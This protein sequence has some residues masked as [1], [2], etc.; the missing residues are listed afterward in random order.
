MFFLCFI[1]MDPANKSMYSIT[2]TIDPSPTNSSPFKVCRPP[3]TGP[4]SKVV[5]E[6]QDMHVVAP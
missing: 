5:S 3:P 4:P 6:V 1:H 2:Q